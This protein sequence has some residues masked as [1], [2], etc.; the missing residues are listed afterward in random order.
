[1]KERKYQFFAIFKKGNSTITKIYK[2]DSNN[3]AKQIRNQIIP[4]GPELISP[5]RPINSKDMPYMF[6]KAKFK[7]LD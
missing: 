4:M 3:H 5:I 6:M 2:A 1:M 7:R